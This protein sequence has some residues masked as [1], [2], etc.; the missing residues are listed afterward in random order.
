MTTPPAPPP[1]ILLSLP[2][3]M[4]AAFAAPGGSREFPEWF[5][6]CD[7]P[8]SKLG[9]AGGVV[10]LLHED[11][12]ALGC[13]GAFDAWVGQAPRLAVLAGGQSRRL[14]AYAPVGKIFIPMPAMRWSLGQ[15]IDETLLDFMLPDFL[16]VLEPAW[17][18]YPLAVC[19]GDVVLRFPERMPPVPDADLV[20]LGMWV[21]PEA[22]SSFGVFFARRSS[23]DTLAF[24]KQKPS[25]E[26]IRSHAR[27]F[28]FLIDTGVWLLGPRAIAVL[29]GQ[30]GWDPERGAFRTGEP[31]FS[32]LYQGF[33]PA[34]GS[35][36]AAPDPLIS[37][38]SAAIL[39]LPGAEFYHLGTSRQLIESVS[40]LQN[41][42][43]DQ[44]GSAPLDLKPHPDI[45]VL[46]ADFPFRTRSVSNRDLWIENCTLDPDQPV[47]RQ[48]V[49]TGVS[50]P[51]FEL[52][53]GICLDVVPV[54]RDEWCLRPYGFD[55]R[56]EGAIG[57]AST[58]WMGSPVVDW[59]RARGL[60]FAEAGLD[61]G[62]DI[63]LAALFPVVDAAGP[64]AQLIAWMQDPVDAPDA[65]A[66]FLGRRLSAMQI[67][68]EANIARLE[69]ARRARIAQTLPRM[70][71]HARSNPFYRLDLSS[72]AS[73]YPATDAAN[74]RPPPDDPLL[75][76]HDA[77]LESAIARSPGEAARH[78]ARA[79]AFLRDAVLEGVRPLLRPPRRSS[80]PDQIVWG[81]SPVRLD[82]AGGWTDTPPYC[83]K[84]GGSVLNVAADING[85]PPVQVFLRV[86][87]EPVV[88]L[89]SIDLGVEARI[90]TFEDLARYA[91]PGSGFALARASLCLAGFHPAFLE[92]APH[93]T[94]REQLAGFGGGIEIS[95]LAAVP[96][97]SGL[98][99]SS[100]LAATLLGTLS[101]ACGL[102]WE[103]AAIVKLVLA[104]EQLLTTGGGWQDQA[105]AI[106]R[107]IK[108]I[109]TSPG[110]AQD[111]A[112]R[113]VPEHLF[114]DGTHLAATRLYYTGIARMASG[115]LHEIVRGMFLNSK[116]RLDT[117][118]DIRRNA[119]TAFEAFLKSD[120]NGVAGCVQRSWHL[121][122]RLDRGT[123]PPPIRAIFDAVADFT[124]GAKLLG[125]GGG[126]YA[127]F[128]A[129]DEEA[130]RRLQRTL[131][132][133]PPNPSARFVSM[134]VSDIGLQVTRS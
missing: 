9:S 25:P 98:G 83:F 90:E 121:N 69:A 115:I 59:F 103:P 80:M 113:W 34:L 51:R 22:A 3:A 42:R 16:R 132:E 112:I 62:C 128:L 8:G 66:R 12:K 134:A 92:G 63:Q 125:A 124:A 91:E 111:P 33:G 21:A 117:L 116:P 130:A 68:E 57:D 86:A 44:T 61:P 81:R 11:W 97:G 19:S 120:W 41:S 71:E 30:C 77:M 82:L 131:E 32:D 50:G 1:Q 74:D 7:P 109:E 17:G 26:E 56:F 101:E 10:R 93:R 118:A 106:Y 133:N 79:F 48:Q 53:D 39:P 29:L 6:S 35:H 5:A 100:I 37:S 96:K 129:K 95:M 2:P 58:L 70:R 126:G 108:L 85:Q 64:D 31:G 110:L 122:R 127:L 89:R 99:T 102:N 15:R 75:A 55:D 43:L 13:P 114:A 14:P 54:G 28:L 84:L 73:F 52:R 36:P 78:E 94:L 47:G 24:F 105:G 20:G 23:P 67:S 107:G 72:V 4:A 76:I 45:H 87:P 49:I 40:S 60:T 119:S 27:D 104:I 38:L 88:V 18:R 46:N 65:R 123:D